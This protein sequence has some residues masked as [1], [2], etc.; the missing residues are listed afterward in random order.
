MV[1]FFSEST[2]S[3]ITNVFTNI[4]EFPA[5]T[6][7]NINPFNTK[8]DNKPFFDDILQRG[9]FSLAIDSQNSSD[10]ERFR[11][12]NSV[13]KSAI[14]YL[15]QE[16]MFNLLQNESLV[17]KGFTIQDM[18]VSCTFEDFQCNTKDFVYS[19]SFNYGNCYTF[20]SALN[21][22]SSMPLTV[23][24][25][26]QASFQLELFSG[27]EGLNDAYSIEH[28]IVVFIHSRTLNPDFNGVRTYVQTGASSNIALTKTNH[29]QVSTVGNPCRDDITPTES[30]SIYYKLAAQWDEYTLQTCRAIY[31]EIEVI[32]K[33]CQCISLKTLQYDLLSRRFNV[34]L[35][36]GS[37]NSA[38]EIKQNSLNTELVIPFSDCPLECER[39]T[40]EAK[41]NIGSYP[42][43][44]YINL[45]NETDN[46][47]NFSDQF[48]RGYVMVRIY[49]ETTY[50]TVITTSKQI[51]PD[52]L[53][54]L[55]GK[56]WVC[57]FVEIVVKRLNLIVF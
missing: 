17:D 57:G 12:A 8:P 39:I 27:I 28:G 21:N 36:H 37:V 18:L 32:I 55:I 48:D 30:D 4:H 43:K 22:L 26:L 38:C 34:S 14:K 50:E 46:V 19:R 23:Q 31:Y 20:N 6:I 49:F 15:K 51:Q 5:V 52:Q 40:Y 9:N 3:S 45:L 44:S 24:T 29:Q 56:C 47:T 35:C 42:G 16:V 25:G 54:G 11:Q 10:L 7:C 41:V 1:S 13:M 33:N 53:I 2:S